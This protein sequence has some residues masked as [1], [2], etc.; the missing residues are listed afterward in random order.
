V[1][2]SRPGSF[3]K[4]A[5]VQAVGETIDFGNPAGMLLFSRSG[6]VMAVVGFFWVRGLS[7]YDPKGCWFDSHERSS[8]CLENVL[9]SMH[10]QGPKRL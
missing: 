5:P 1:Y 2:R 3:S 10:D 8:R 4:S 6:S 9:G 7:G